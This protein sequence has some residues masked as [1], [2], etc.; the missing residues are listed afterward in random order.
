[1]PS[2]CRRRTGVESAREVQDEQ[3]HDGGPDE[4]DRERA[5]AVEY[6]GQ[7][8][9]QEHRP[10]GRETD[11]RRQSPPPAHR[12]HYDGEDE[13][14][15]HERPAALEVREVVI[16]PTGGVFRA[17]QHH[18]VAAFE[19]RHVG[20]EDHL[21]QPHRAPAIRTAGDADAHVTA[22]VLR[23]GARRGSPPTSRWHRTDSAGGPAL[24]GRECVRFSGQSATRP[25]MVA[26]TSGTSS[27]QQQGSDARRRAAVAAGRARVDDR[28]PAHTPYER[29]SAADV[30]RHLRSHLHA[31]GRAGDRVAPTA[32]RGGW[33][34]PRSGRRSARAARAAT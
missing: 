15:Q 30:D 21:R 6:R 4:R 7:H 16:D 28:P 25:T 17:G 27:G 10:R 13:G 8:E 20:A 9:P 11:Q 24:P 26:S 22:H 33:C 29:R 23:R 19:T 1:M 31:V 18:S 34:S 14:Q 12:D 3:H 2:S 5:L 32:G